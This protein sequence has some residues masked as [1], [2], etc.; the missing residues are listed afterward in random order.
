MTKKQPKNE[1]INNLNEDIQPNDDLVTTDNDQEQPKQ[2]SKLRVTKK[3]RTPAQIEATRKMI[4]AR[5]ERAKQQLKN[6]TKKQT[7][8]PEIID[9]ESSSDEEPPTPAP[10]PKLKRQPKKKIIYE[11]S[12]SEEEEPEIVY[13][14]KRKPKKKK[15]KKKIIY[16]ESESEE[17]RETL[18]IKQNKPKQNNYID[19]S[20]DNFIPS[21]IRYI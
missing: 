21:Y 19:N 6:K 15:P 8:Q 9:S 18:R 2:K 17:E 10:K 11:E 1:V 14:K 5:K 16:E 3:E 12:E 7:K 4:E 13:V 20:N